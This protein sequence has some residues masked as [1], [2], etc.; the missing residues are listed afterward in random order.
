MFINNKSKTGV[1]E[2]VVIDP[3]GAFQ[4]LLFKK[5]DVIVWCKTYLNIRRST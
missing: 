4:L 3:Q 2:S 1:I 5:I